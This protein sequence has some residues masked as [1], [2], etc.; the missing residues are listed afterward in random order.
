[1]SEA[2]TRF[3]DWAVRVYADPAVSSACLELQDVHGHCVT[4]LLW[5]V[6]LGGEGVS[7]DVDAAERAIASARAWSTEVLVPIRVVRRRM[8]SP[9]D[10]MADAARLGVRERVK[11]LELES[12]RELM[13]A[14][15]ALLPT[16]GTG[17][18][19]RCE[20]QN[21]MAVAHRWSQAVPQPAL[22]RLVEAVVLQ[23]AAPGRS[24]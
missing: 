8:K 4:L 7:V 21:V 19:R 10:N 16:D 23:V 15:A 22:L 12:E 18:V 17:S 14:L 6:W 20:Q 24:H 1:V 13:S 11:V 3:W 5:A 9:I 2:A